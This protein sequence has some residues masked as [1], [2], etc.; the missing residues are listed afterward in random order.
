MRLI[1]EKSSIQ[2]LILQFS[3]FTIG[4]IIA[5][6]FREFFTL[7]HEFGHAIFL[8]LSSYLNSCI[9]RDCNTIKCTITK[10][11][12]N[13]L[14]YVTKSNIDAYLRNNRPHTNLIIRLYA[15]GGILFV[16]TTLIALYV[17]IPSTFAFGVAFIILYF[18]LMPLCNDR[19]T[20]DLN[21]FLN[22]YNF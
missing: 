6:L 14:R 3:F 18:E 22:P 5:F 7:L 10:E 19:P 13:P 12:N 9:R 21:V 16:F 17:V 1:F 20:N 11:S 2:E 15:I 4:C 8:H